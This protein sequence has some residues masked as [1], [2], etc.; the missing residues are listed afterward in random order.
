MLENIFDYIKRDFIRQAVTLWISL[1][2]L[3]L[4][5]GM[6]SANDVLKDFTF[7]TINGRTFDAD[8]LNDSPMVVNIMAH[9]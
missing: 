7:T 6:T 3:L 8:T 2:L 1:V 4:V 9:W 5:S